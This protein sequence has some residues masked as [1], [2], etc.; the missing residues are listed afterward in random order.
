MTPELRA[1]IRKFAASFPDLV[2]SKIA[3]HFNVSQ[4][5]VSETLAGYRE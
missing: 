3:E 4:G 1:Q 5:R 2:Q